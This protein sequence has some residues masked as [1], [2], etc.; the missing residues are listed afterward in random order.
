MATEAAKIVHSGMDTPNFA[1]ARAGRPS[2]PDGNLVLE[3]LS[4][5]SSARSIQTARELLLEYGQFVARQPDIATFCYGDLEAE[6]AGL[7]HS[8]LDRQGGA[9]LAYLGPAAVG[10][11]AWRALP[12][13]LLSHA[14]EL[15]R[16]W[17]RP[18]GRGHGLGRRL[19]QA[20]IDR[21]RAAEKSALLLDTAPQSMA[22]AVE[23]YRQMGF[24][25]CPPYIGQAAEGIL[26]MTKTL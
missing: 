13:P 25:E 16:L 2:N 7:P 1:S 20:V 17:I 14:W 12:D 21:A 15:K 9:L 3:F 24:V 23:V 10:F 6:A 5:T 19:V 22:A 18:Q 4:A 26:Y 8:Y 11:V